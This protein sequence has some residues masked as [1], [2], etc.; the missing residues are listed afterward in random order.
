MHVKD[1][2]GFI[3]RS[4]LALVMQNLGEKLEPEEIQS[5]I[6]EADLGKGENK[7]K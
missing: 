5:M 4:E 2:N 1:G 6:N 3:N 7:N